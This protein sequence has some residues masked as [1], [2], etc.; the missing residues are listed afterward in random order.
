MSTTTCT[1]NFLSAVYLKYFLNFEF[2]YI[3]K[4]F[5]YPHIEEIHLLQQQVGRKEVDR[6]INKYKKKIRIK[7]MNKEFKF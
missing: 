3:R 7:I 2:D 4:N 1:I 5:I 6:R